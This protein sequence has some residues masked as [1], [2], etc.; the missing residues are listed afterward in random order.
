MEG[1]KEEYLGG[2]RKKVFSHDFV[3]TAIA[4]LCALESRDPSTQVGAC[5]SDKENRIISTG[6]NHNPKEWSIERFPWRNDSDIIGEENTKYPYIIHAEVDAIT[7]CC[8]RRILEGSTI[9]VTLFPCIQCAKIIVASGIKKVVYNDRR[10]NTESICAE[11]LLRE[12]GVEL[13]HA[14]M[15]EDYNILEESTT[16]VENEEQ[17]RIKIK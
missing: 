4:S 1:I 8:D 15:I 3:C 10:L 16:S 12:C 13:V 11:R 6:F 5:I 9:Y 7:K 14:S 2:A 17:P